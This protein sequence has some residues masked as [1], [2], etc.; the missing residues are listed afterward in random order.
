MKNTTR[1]ERIFFIYSA[2]ITICLLIGVLLDLGF[3]KNENTYSKWE[4]NF[5][6]EEYEKPDGGNSII[7]TLLTH[8]N[9]EFATTCLSADSDIRVTIKAKKYL[10]E[11]GEKKKL[12]AEKSGVDLI[13]GYSSSNNH[14]IM[15][16]Y[17]KGEEET[18]YGNLNNEV[19][20]FPTSSNYNFGDLYLKLEEGVHEI[21]FS[22]SE[23]DDTVGAEYKVT[24]NVVDEREEGLD[25]QYAGEYLKKFT[26]EE[27]GDYELFVIQDRPEFSLSLNGITVGVFNNYSMLS[28]YPMFEN[29][30]NFRFTIISTKRKNG[31]IEVCSLNETQ[32]KGLYFIEVEAK[33]SKEYKRVIY[34]CY[35]FMT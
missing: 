32:E 33:D 15:T 13:R 25:I 31:V 27:T 28:N 24:I 9:S 11:N 21:K 10:F 5:S 6:I 18:K 2:I 1:L 3:C 7:S 19:P 12:L 35:V 20:M 34:R 17:F 16:Y 30:D 14:N 8:E 29:D 26:A 23:E 22:F 4:V